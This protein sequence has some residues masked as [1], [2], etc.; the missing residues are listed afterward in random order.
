MSNSVVFLTPQPVV[1][2][3]NRP[4]STR[5]AYAKGKSV[6]LRARRNDQQAAGW[7]R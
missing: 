6:W 7:R 1:V 2:F 3:L 4:D 5:T